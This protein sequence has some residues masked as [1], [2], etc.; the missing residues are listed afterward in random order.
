[1]P[2]EPTRRW[3]HWWPLAALPLWLI[4]LAAW[5][6]LALPDEGRYG[7]VAYEMLQNGDALTPTLFGMPYFHKPPLMYWIDMAALQLLGPTK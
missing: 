6:Q 7:G 3:P 1:S 4:A 2:T 5:R